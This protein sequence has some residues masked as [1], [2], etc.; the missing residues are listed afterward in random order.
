MSNVARVPDR[1]ALRVTVAV[2][3]VAGCTLALQ[4]LLTR[5]LAAV[6]FY[7]FAFFS[8]SLALLGTGAGALLVYVKQGWFDRDDARP[9]LAR[10]ATGFA[11]L[12]LAVPFVLVRLDYSFENLEV[13][14]GFATT[15]AIAGVLAALPFTAAGIV[16]ALAIRRYVDSVDRV[17]AFDLAGA[18][19]GSLIV[20]PLLW[21]VDVPTLLVSLGAVAGIAAALFAPIRSRELQAA[22]GVAVLGIALTVVASTT[23]AYKL[24][25]AFA[26]NAT[27]RTV[28]DHWTPI[29]R[30]TGYAPTKPGTDALV[31]YDQDVAP[32]PLHRRGGPTPDWRSMGLGPQ[33]IAFGLVPGGRALI[34]GG[35]GGRDIYNALS[36][37]ERRVDVIELNRRMRETVE[38]PLRRW[39]GGPYTLPGV[40]SA[41]GDGRSTL[42]RR[43]TRYDA[44]NIGFTNTL[45]ASSSGSAYALSES[46]LYTTE[47][48]DEYLDHLTPN[49]VLSVSRLYRFAGDEALRATVLALRA[50]EDRGVKN[51]RDHVV[52]LLGRDTLAA[53]FATVIVRKRPFTNAELSRI[54]AQAPGRSRGVAFAPGGPYQR[55]WQGLARTTDLDSFCSSYPLNVC[56]TTDDKPFFLNSTRL[57]DIGDPLPAGSTFIARTPFVVLLI[58]LGI[59]LVLA[60]LA[61]VLPLFAVRDRPRPPMGSLV[62]FAAIGL[63]FLMLEIVLVQRF[64]LF[65]GFPTYALSVVLFSLLLFTG[66]GAFLSSRG[67]DPRR[68]LTAALSTACGLMLVLA[69]A[70]EPLLRS[71]IDL[72]F[73]ARVVLTVVL[74]APLGLTLGMAMPIGLRRL[75]ALHPDGVPWAWGINGI[76]S[77]LASALGVFIAIVAGFTVATL[78]A[79]ACYLVAIAHVVRG[80]WPDD[81]LASAE[82]PAVERPVA[83]AAR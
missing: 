81:G 79:L 73:A 60:A 23:D 63:G 75:S 43:D 78:A 42:A 6:L 54:K 25:T 7:H 52:V 76:T 44:I 74:L 82:P 37:G 40:S 61:F 46:T 53:D 41:I 55:E 19:I 48:F 29:S 39:S 83:A 15:L 33:S 51:P 28:A 5:L 65:L 67:S 20:V 36:S 71:L 50:L 45:T 70:L 58:A 72:S 18:A 12:S 11:L 59:L 32:V 2:G 77:V 10:W 31:S 69:F 9:L 24:D 66:G 27:L 47:A 26:D 49:G 13:T 62:F 8:I 30:V 35:G 4:V 1:P 22:A 64:V 57:R 14:T 17:Y 21:V 3:L 16:I 38:G 68:T 56:P 34:I 80:R